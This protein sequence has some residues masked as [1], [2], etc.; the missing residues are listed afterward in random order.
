MWRSSVAIEC[1]DRMWR[2]N[3][4]VEC[5]GVAEGACARGGDRE[6]VGTNVYLVRW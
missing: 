6:T 4:A 2:S 1:G 3:V 5:G